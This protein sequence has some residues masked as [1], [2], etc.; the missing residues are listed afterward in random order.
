MAPL[1]EVEPCLTLVLSSGKI[2][3]VL[4]L[5]HNKHALNQFVNFKELPFPGAGGGGWDT[6][7]EHN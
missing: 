4:E 6:D 7:E 5:P 3:N 2:T 1:A